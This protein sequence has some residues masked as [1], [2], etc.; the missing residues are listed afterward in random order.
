MYSFKV[1]FRV[2][3]DVAL[4][5]GYEHLIHPQRKEK[6]RKKKDK[7]LLSCVGPALIFLHWVS[8]VCPA[9]FSC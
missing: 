4:C 6:E 3:T 9:W 7:V 2:M 8:S 5:L 1:P